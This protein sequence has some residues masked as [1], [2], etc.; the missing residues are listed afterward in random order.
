MFERRG[1]GYEQA[2]VDLCRVERDE[3]AVAFC[4][5]ARGRV[6]TEAAHRP[7]LDLRPDPGPHR[8][9]PAYPV[10]QVCLGSAPV[11]LAPAFG[12]IQ[13]STEIAMN[14]VSS[15]P[16]GYSTDVVSLGL[17]F[18]DQCFEQD[19]PHFGCFAVMISAT[20]HGRQVRGVDVPHADR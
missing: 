13:S 12:S 15:S 19:F 17:N 6:V 10:V 9:A 16:G 18:V 5:P 8:H 1:S 20:R 7:L 11:G 2:E 14:R 4:P 3:V